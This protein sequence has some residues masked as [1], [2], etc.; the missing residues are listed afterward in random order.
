MEDK[1]NQAVIEGIIESNFVFNH[2]VFG[3]RFY[4]VN[5]A[6]RRTSGVYDIVPVMISERLMDVTQNQKG[7]GV[8]VSGQFRSYNRHDE[9][10][11][12][13]ILSLFAREVEYLTYEESVRATANSVYLEGYVCKKPVYRVTPLGREVADI[14]LAVNRTYGK[15]DYIPCICWGRNAKF[16]AELQVGDRLAMH[17]RI[18]SR[19]YIK[20]YA[21]G[22]E[23]ERTAFEVSVNILEHIRDDE[24]FKVEE[25]R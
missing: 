17:G 11:C 4:L 21:D 13:L 3:E 20:R 12:R 6:V 19:N 9:D 18:Q 15:S 7:L 5:V 2:E 24:G 10:K 23:E 1:N 22:R 25:G 8:M 16:A 14:T